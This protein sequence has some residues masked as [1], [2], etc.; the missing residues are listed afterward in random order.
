MTN[1]KKYI[2]NRVKNIEVSLIKQMPLKA[3]KL[4]L[5]GKFKPDEI[6]SLGQ[7]IPSMATPKYITDYVIEKLQSDDKIC[8]YSLQPGTPELKQAIATD[9]K[10]KTGRKV[11]P[12]KEIFVSV[13]AMEALAAG[14][15]TI[16]NKDD[17]IILADP[18]YSSH[19]EQILFAEGKPVFVPLNPDKNWEFDLKVF[20]QKITPR[21]KAIIICNPA[22]P[23]GAII[24]KEQL[25]QI[26]EVA[27]ENDLFVFAD[28]TYSYLVYD[29]HPFTSLLEYPELKDKLIYTFSFSKQFAMTG[30]RLGYMYAPKFIIE[31]SL[32][33]HDAFAICAPTVSQ[34]AGFAALTKEPYPNDPNMVKIY[35]KRKKLMCQKLDQLS[36]LFSYQEPKGAYYILVKYLKTDLNSMDFATKLLEETGVIAIPGT[37]FGPKGEGH[38][39]LSFCSTEE[40]IETAFERIKKWNETL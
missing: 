29:N 35:N 23:T 37:G 32:K 27:I 25:N 21:T 9:L 22:N 30:W 1:Q 33:I 4:V 24:E 39:R 8:K 20:K 26:V 40:E 12:N 36:D 19:I 2:S 13:G 15:S 7:G 17:E 34:Y 6:V 18:S 16:L 5:D 14:L 10:E 28:E 38:I 31:Q 3:H 11:D